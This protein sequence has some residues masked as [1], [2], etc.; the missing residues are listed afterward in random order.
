MCYREKS[1]YK[2]NKMIFLYIRN[3]KKGKLL[4]DNSK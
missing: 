2:Q 4:N 3:I 1:N